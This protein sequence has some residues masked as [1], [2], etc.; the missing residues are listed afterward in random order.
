M[1]PNNP[2][3]SGQTVDVALQALS[4]P[5]TAT[6]TAVTCVDCLTVLPRRLASRPIVSWRR[7]GAEEWDVIAESAEHTVESAQ[8]RARI[9]TRLAQV[10]EALE[11][12][13][14]LCPGEER[15]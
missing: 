10:R 13:P 15:E 2:F 5:L 1:G 8:Y 3:G 12:E 6:T 7:Y 14:A 11:A 9:R 4:P